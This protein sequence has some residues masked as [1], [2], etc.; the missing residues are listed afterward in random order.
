M[1]PQCER[2]PSIT[3]FHVVKLCACSV[4][5]LPQALTRSSN[6]ASRQRVNGKLSETVAADIGIQVLCLVRFAYGEFVSRQ[7]MRALDV[8]PALQVIG[9][10]LELA[11][12]AVER[13]AAPDDIVLLL[14]A[15]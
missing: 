4:G 9:G 14:A 13:I 3:S 10:H 8:V 1:T 15:G 5:G 6:A 2:R 12:N 11:R 7:D